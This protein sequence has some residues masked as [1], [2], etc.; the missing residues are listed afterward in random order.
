MP[1]HDLKPPAPSTLFPSEKNV[2]PQDLSAY[3]VLPLTFINDNKYRGIFVV[4]LAREINALALAAFD[5]N[6]QMVNKKIEHTFFPE[7]NQSGKTRNISL[8]RAF[9]FKSPWTPFTTI[10]KYLAEN[11]F[12]N[13]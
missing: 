6:G 5:P 3:E 7:Y 12:G 2:A 11:Y 8:P 13:L 1:T 4:S 9:F 10:I